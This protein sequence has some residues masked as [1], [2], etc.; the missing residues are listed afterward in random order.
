MPQFIDRFLK[1]RYTDPVGAMEAIAVQKSPILALLPKPVKRGE[2]V[3]DSLRTYGPRGHSYDFASAQAVSSQSG[4]GGSEV[5][6]FI[7]PFGQYYSS[8]QMPNRAIAVAQ[9]GNEEAFLEDLAFEMDGALAAFGD[10]AATKIFGPIG[11]SIGRIED[12]DQG[13]NAGEIALY[14]SGDAYNFQQF[15]IIQASSGTGVGAQTVRAGLGYVS[16]AVPNADVTGGSTTGWHL[17]I[18]TSLALAQAGTAGQPTG[19]V[20]N[21]YLFP[22]GDVLNGSDLSDGQIRSLQGFIPLSNDTATYLNCARTAPGA[23]GFRLTA[24]QVAGMS[25]RD[26]IQALVT[27]GYSHFGANNLDIIG[28][29]PR[30]WQALSNELQDNAYQLQTE[31]LV[32]G[33]VALK[34]M[35]CAGPVKVIA[36][37][38]VKESDIW[39]LTSKM[40]KIYNWTGFPGPVDQDGLKMRERDTGAVWEAR[41]EAYNCL[42]VTGMPHHFGRCPSDTPVV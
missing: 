42:S 21:D 34:I 5:E 39:A 3:V 10:R 14:V 22:N 2:S 25:L 29:G 32:G 41:F 7:L 19:W 33:A 12:I 6:T 4:I 36:D 8:V 24:T 35:T 11:G 9:G 31:T 40:L 27:E 38:H 18:A 37:P 1:R 15:A 28:V 23:N 26:R 20:D 16:Q 13:G 17:K 30:T